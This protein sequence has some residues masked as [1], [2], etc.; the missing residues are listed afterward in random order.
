MSR[1]NKEHY[2][3]EFATQVVE[4]FLSLDVSE[5]SPYAHREYC[6]C[7]LVKKPY[8]NIGIS[9]FLDARS[10]RTF[11]ELPKHE[12][13]EF[14]SKQSDD[15]MSLTVVGNALYNSD[16]FEQ[17]NQVLNRQL[18]DQFVNSTS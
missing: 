18:L 1:Y 7:G 13:I 9:N 8:G 12:F 2:G 17:G 15:T 4:H 6:G 16:K 3:I 11:V 5:W 14:L 10:F